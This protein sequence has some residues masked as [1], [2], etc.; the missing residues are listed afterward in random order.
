MKTK[1]N[2]VTP[3]LCLNTS[4]INFNECVLDR[5]SNVGVLRPVVC[6]QIVHTNKFSIK[7]SNTVLG[8]LGPDFEMAALQAGFWALQAGSWA[9]RAGNLHFGH[10]PADQCKSLVIISLGLSSNY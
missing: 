5:L 7:L 6:I 4:V 9:L 3:T 1:Q 10:P 8:P 2:N